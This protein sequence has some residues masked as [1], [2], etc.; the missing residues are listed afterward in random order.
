MPSSLSETTRVESS[1]MACEEGIAPE[2]S[3]WGNTME[4]SA[5]MGA[6][7]NSISPRAGGGRADEVRPRS[8]GAVTPWCYYR[9]YSTYIVPLH[10]FYSGCYSR[11][12]VQSGFK[13]TFELFLNF[14]ILVP[15]VTCKGTSNFLIH[16]S[17]SKFVVL[18]T[19]S[20]KIF[21][22]L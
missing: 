16:V 17:Q 13:F 1:R 19:R 7:S 6:T 14:L 20:R 8:V 5:L 15:I 21:G 2:A 18:K 11:I 4:I 3:M 12:L 9:N 10:Y 22:N